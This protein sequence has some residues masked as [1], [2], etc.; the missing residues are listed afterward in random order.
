MRNCFIEAKLTGYRRI[1]VMIYSQAKDT[2]T[3]SFYL[4]KDN[5]VSRELQIDKRVTSGGVIIYNLELGED[6]EFGHH[7]ELNLPSFSP[8]PIDVSE[9]PEFPDFDERYAYDGDDLGAIYSRGETSFNVWAPIS[10]A[11]QL[12]LFNEKDNGYSLYDMNRTDRGVYRVKVKGDLKGRRY[13]YIV[14]NY[15]ITKET[16]DPYGKGVSLN[17]EHSVVVDIAPIEKRK[18]ITPKSEIHSICEHIIYETHVRDLTAAKGTNIISKGTFKGFIEAGRVT[19]GG[20]PAGLDYLKWLEVT[21]VQ[22]QPVLDYCTVDETSIDKT[23]NWGYDPISF[24]ALE[25]SL[26]SDPTSPDLRLYELRELVDTLHKNDLRV[27]LDVVYNHVYDYLAFDEEKIVPNYFFRRKNNLYISEYSGCGND[28]NSSHFM[29][30]KLIIDS[31]AYLVKTFDVDGFRF[32]L[33]GL[34]DYETISEAYKACKALKE[35]IIFYGEGWDMDGN[36]REEMTSIGNC[37]KLPEFAFFNDSYR[38]IVKGPT[39]ESELYKRG[40]VGGDASYNDGLIYAMFGSYPKFMKASQSLNFVEC[41]DN[42]SLFDKL[43]K[44][45]EGESEDT[46]LKRVMLANSIVDISFGVPFFHMGQE[47]GQSK[48]GLGNTYNIPKINYLDYALVDERWDMVVYFKLLNHIRRRTRFFSHTDSDEIKSHFDI[49]TNHYPLVIYSSTDK[50]VCEG[51]GNEV[52]VI[53]NSDNTSYPLDLGGYYK[54]YIYNGGRL[55]TEEQAQSLI[56]PPIS[57]TI[58]YR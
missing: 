21:T 44:S 38:D 20:H 53:L 34:I 42:H 35:D 37:Y 3:H 16:N 45:N 23:Y 31:L 9:A 11:V 36:N 50:E 25:G 6:F 12:K 5:A 47:I 46:L 40:Y 48:M 56:V 29:A 28:F 14:N 8:V 13:H 43:S 32:D 55:V 4:I 15:S 17:S 52:V 18:K 51:I 58:M 27:T 57:F 26:S 10:L 41:H 22:L 54:F 7:Y 24:F 19:D 33:M 30:R 39:Y 49:D 2:D 1:N